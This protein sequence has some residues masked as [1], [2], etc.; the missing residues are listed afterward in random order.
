M[1]TINKFLTNEDGST[2]VEW[3]VLT[4]AIIGVSAAVSMTVFGGTNTTAR[5]L[6]NDVHSGVNSRSAA[7]VSSTTLPVAT[8][9]IYTHLPPTPL[10]KMAVQTAPVQCENIRTIDDDATGLPQIICMKT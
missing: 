6:T 1:N 10:I 2:S 3:V 4:A 7:L 8:P 5:T 9:T